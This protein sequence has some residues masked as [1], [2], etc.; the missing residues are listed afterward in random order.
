MKASIKFS[1]LL[2][3]TLVLSGCA[4]CPCKQNAAETATSNTVSATKTVAAAV[5]PKVM[6]EPVAVVP[7][8]PTTPVTKKIPAAVMK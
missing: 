6:Q 3:S 1:A 5:A 4:A 7:V 2:L 8:T